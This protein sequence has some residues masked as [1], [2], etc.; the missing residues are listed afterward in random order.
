M[1]HFSDLASEVTQHLPHTLLSE[2]V[3]KVCLGQREETQ[4]PLPMAVVSGSYC[5]RNMWVGDVV[6]VVFGKSTCHATSPRAGD[7]REQADG[8]LNAQP[9]APRSKGARSWVP[10]IDL[11]Q[12]IP[13]SPILHLP[14]PVSHVSVLVLAHAP[15]SPWCLQVFEG[16]EQVPPSGLLSRE[17]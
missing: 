10:L 3:T 7:L 15:S 17:G 12:K 5:K 1:W 11:T 4:A 6:V 13:L 14:H 16:K 9:R 2:A 8:A